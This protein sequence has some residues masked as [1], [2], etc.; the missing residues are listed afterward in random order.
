VR[1]ENGKLWSLFFTDSDLQPLILELWELNLLYR[2]TEQILP[3]R[4][5]EAERFL[6]Q[7]RFDIRRRRPL[8]MQGIWRG[9]MLSGT[10]EA[11]IVLEKTD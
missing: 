2:L 8:E 9:R 5:E 1:L 6:Q 3:C 7:T 11:I 10:L 4:T